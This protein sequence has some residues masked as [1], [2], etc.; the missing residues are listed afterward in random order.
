MV[1]HG[2][3]DFFL[4]HFREARDD[5]FVGVGEGIV[6]AEGGAEDALVAVDGVVGDGVGEV[7]EVHAEL[8][9]SAGEGVAAHDGVAGFGFPGHSVIAGFFGWGAWVVLF[10]FWF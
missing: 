1:R 3:G 9:R 2:L 4:A 8:V 10:W 5:V 6:G 7:L